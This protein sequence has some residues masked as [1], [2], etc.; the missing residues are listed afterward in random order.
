MGLSVRALSS[1]GFLHQGF[2]VTDFLH[3]F[4]NSD[5]WNSIFS[6]WGLLLS[7]TTVLMAATS[8]LRS[9]PLPWSLTVVTKPK[10]IKIKLKIV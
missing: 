2:I 6:F 1:G 8:N 3:H 9:K 7:T 4:M 10:M 5:L